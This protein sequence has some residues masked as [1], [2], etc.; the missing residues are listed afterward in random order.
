MLLPKGMLGWKNGWLALRVTIA[1]LAM[2]A[3]VWWVRGLFIAIPIGAG[4]TA[5]LVCIFLLRVITPEDWSMLKSLRL[6]AL[7]RLGWN[8]EQP[9]NI[10]EPIDSAS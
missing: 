6:N 2:A 1:G 8:K 5:Y 7:R 4:I 3:V 9:A 10:G